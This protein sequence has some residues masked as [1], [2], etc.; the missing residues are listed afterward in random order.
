MVVLSFPRQRAFN[1][2]QQGSHRGV[3]FFAGVVP[4]EPRPQLTESDDGRRAHQ[5]RRDRGHDT[6]QDETEAQQKRRKRDQKC[7]SAV[8]QCRIVVH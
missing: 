7:V 3:G 5:K 1:V 2:E 4:H 6:F 8:K